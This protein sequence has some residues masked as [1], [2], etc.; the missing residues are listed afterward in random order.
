M[1]KGYAGFPAHALAESK[2][3]QAYR[4]GDRCFHII[5][6]HVQD[7]TGREWGRSV[8]GG[9]ESGSFPLVTPEDR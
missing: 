2:A 4:R 9:F 3:V 8:I 1:C 6:V 7:A 5:T